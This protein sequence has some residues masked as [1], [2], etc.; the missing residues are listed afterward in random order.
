[1]STNVMER[2]SSFSQGDITITGD[3]T[4]Q[5]FSWIK[6]KIKATDELL[7]NKY[8][9]ILEMLNDLEDDAGGRDS[10]S[11]KLD[12]L[13]SMRVG[14]PMFVEIMEKFNIQEVVVSG[15]GL[16]YGVYFEHFH[17]INQ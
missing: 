9:N 17:N 11:D 6:E 5:D 15:T 16:W 3:L 14:L 13:L 7:K 10:A 4:Y 12:S 8:S 2:F 1:M